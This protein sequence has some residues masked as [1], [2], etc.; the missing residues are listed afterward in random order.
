MNS[1]YEITIVFNDGWTLG[2]ACES[3]GDIDPE[4]L[5]IRKKLKEW[6]EDATVRVVK[7]SPQVIGVH[8]IKRTL[9]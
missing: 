2:V 9:K 6:G 3:R 7:T 4:L 1:P 8:E 5:R